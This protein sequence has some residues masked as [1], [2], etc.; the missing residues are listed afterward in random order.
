MLNSAILNI[1]MTFCQIPVVN[2]ESKNHC[3]CFTSVTN[4]ERY[5]Q[6]KTKQADDDAVQ[7]KYKHFAPL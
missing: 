3:L 7:K 4:E 5:V 2:L 6:Q 1:G